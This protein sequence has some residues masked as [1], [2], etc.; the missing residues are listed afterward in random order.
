MTVE[1][2]QR[3]LR[4]FA[5]EREWEQFHDPKNLVMALSG[6]VG[7]LSEVFQWLTPAESQDVMVDPRRAEQ[8]RHEL[9]DVYAYLLRLADVLEVSLAE[10][11]QEKMEL[12]ARRYP[13]EASRG[14]ARKYTEMSEDGS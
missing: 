7:E 5:R 14:H 12:N 13:V 8:V 9:A 10:A 3:S 11:L 1:D 6:E 4:D 2:Q